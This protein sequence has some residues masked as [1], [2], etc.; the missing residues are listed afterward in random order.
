[1]AKGRV[2][3]VNESAITVIRQNESDY[4]SLTD[5]TSTFKEGSGLIGKCMTNKN[6]LECLGFWEKMNNPDFN[7]PEFGVIGQEAGTIRFTM[8]FSEKIGQL[9]KAL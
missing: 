2:I 4:I 8:Q 6:T 9:K 5:M 7:Y 1:M 3:Q